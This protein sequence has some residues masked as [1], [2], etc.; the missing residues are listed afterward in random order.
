MKS[1]FQ[2]LCCLLFKNGESYKNTQMIDEK[3]LLLYNE[4]FVKIYSKKGNFPHEFLMQSYV[5]SS[6]KYVPA[7]FSFH[8]FRVM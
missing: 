3:H 6:W 8:S 4:D 5:V 2:L 7:Y 1:D